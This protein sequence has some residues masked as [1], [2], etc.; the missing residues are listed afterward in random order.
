MRKWTERCILL[1]IFFE[2][3][4]AMPYI[5]PAGKWTIG[6]GHVIKQGEKFTK[7][8]EQ[9]A[10]ALLEQDLDTAQ[11]AV[12]RHVK[13]PLTNNQLDALVSF[14]FNA[15][16]ENFEKSTML[17]MVNAGKH[18]EA[19]AEFD[20]WVYAKSPK[21]GQKI[22]LTGLVRRRKAEQKLFMEEQ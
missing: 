4:R 22:K 21:T 1:V 13:A 16:E 18:K 12:L 10:R 14:V 8:N 3:F 15:G 2:T 17:K 19:G 5:C 6:Y 9:K 7:I 20:R 11:D